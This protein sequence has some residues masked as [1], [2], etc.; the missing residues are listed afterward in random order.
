MDQDNRTT[1]CSS[2]EEKYEDARLGN[3]LSELSDTKDIL[4][5]VTLSLLERGEILESVES[6]SSHLLEASLQYEEAVEERVGRSCFTSSLYTCGGYLTMDNCMKGL[7]AFFSGVKQLSKP[8][9]D[10][11]IDVLTE[12]I[13]ILRGI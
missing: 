8:A 9:I 7:Y 12:N 13:E 10:M 6:K 5:N 1:N 4:S 2:G 11:T 3:I